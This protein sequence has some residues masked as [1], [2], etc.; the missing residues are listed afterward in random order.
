MKILDP[1]GFHSKAVITVEHHPV[2]I[3]LVEDFE[4]IESPRDSQKIDGIA[5]VDFSDKVL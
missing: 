2:W 4:L 5:F 3:S 1:L